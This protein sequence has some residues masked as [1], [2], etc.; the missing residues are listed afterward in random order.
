VLGEEVLARTLSDANPP[1]D[2]ANALVR[3]SVERQRGYFGRNDATAAVIVVRAL[4]EA[5]GQ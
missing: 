1:N 2:L 4:D 3:A 5:G